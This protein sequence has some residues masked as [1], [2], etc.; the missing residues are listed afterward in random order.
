M[1]N[2]YIPSLL[3]GLA[4]VCFTVLIALDKVSGDVGLAAI[5]GLIGGTFVPSPVAKIEP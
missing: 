1:K 5:V 3:V 2:I 4:I